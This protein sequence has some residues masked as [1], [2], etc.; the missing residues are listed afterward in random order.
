MTK[1]DRRTFLWVVFALAFL[2]PVQDNAIHPTLPMDPAY[3]DSPS[4]TFWNSSGTSKLIADN[5]AYDEFVWKYH[6]NAR[7][8]FK[9]LPL[10]AICKWY[11]E[12]EH[13]RMNTSFDEPAHII[14]VTSTSSSLPSDAILPPSGK[15]RIVV[16][17]PCNALVKTHGC[18]TGN[19]VL[20]SYLSRM[21]A[22]HSMKQH[23]QNSTATRFEVDLS[24]K[25]YANDET[26]RSRL[27]LPWLTGNFSATKD[28]E[29][30]QNYWKTDIPTTCVDRYGGWLRSPLLYMLPLIREDL[31]RMAVALVGA[32][33]LKPAHPAHD[34]LK[35]A[36]DG[37]PSFQPP[38]LSNVELDDVAIHFRCGDIMGSTWYVFHFVKFRTI[39][40]QISNATTQQSIGIVTQPF[41]TQTSSQKRP[42]DDADMFGSEL[43]IELTLSFQE[44]LQNGFPSAR[45]SIRNGP[46]ETIALAYARLILA[47]QAFAAPDSTF[48]VFPVLATFGTGYQLKA[49]KPGMNQGLTNDRF[50]VE[51][52]PHIV[53][54][55][56]NPKLPVR[57][58]RELRLANQTRARE[59]ILTWF[60]VD[61]Y[62]IL[63]QP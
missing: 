21:A 14:R 57:T 40:D 2:L 53:F 62:Q 26:I 43:C 50:L 34:Y 37:G 8:E 32:P 10:F 39:A 16:Q 42:V 25:D 55:D 5:D 22:M 33:P 38:L 63:P 15:V 9:H 29:T 24:C 31:R 46:E 19:W 54:L 51:E 30:I 3:V 1:R 60:R 56:P 20:H 41:R 11:G 61:D 17:H 12:G 7:G 6:V 28:L 27:V 47:D 45:I 18:G 48:S 58:T 49:G 4:S 23:L 36:M 52:D 35:I 44:Y 13:R 59:E